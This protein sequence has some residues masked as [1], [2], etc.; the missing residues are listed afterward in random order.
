MS[1]TLAAVTFIFRVLIG[2]V[3][4]FTSAFGSCR[5]RS[6]DV[7]CCHFRLP[8]QSPNRSLIPTKSLITLQMLGA[9]WCPHSALSLLLC[10]LFFP[11]AFNPS[12]QETAHFRLIECSQNCG[13][14]L[15]RVSA[16]HL[17][18]L[19]SSCLHKA[20][21]A[22]Q[23]A[24]DVN[25]YAQNV[26]SNRGNRDFDFSS[27]GGGYNRPR[28]QGYDRRGGGAQWRSP[29]RDV[30]SRADAPRAPRIEVE[31]YDREALPQSPPEEV[32]AFYEEN[33]ITVVVGGSPSCLPLVLF[34]ASCVWPATYTLQKYRY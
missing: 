32:Q 29:G 2:F 10:F 6:L 1:E 3:T 13:R 19:L 34:C 24:D 28:S 9:T 21:A 20:Q 12:H 4:T 27:F 15:S 23:Y 18:S 26:G 7:M 14:Y 31:P 17:T 33:E 25:E 16:V 22:V 5:S 8:L 30:R 11:V